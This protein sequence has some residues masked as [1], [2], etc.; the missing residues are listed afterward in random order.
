MVVTVHNR[1]VIP[2]AV[3]PMLF[4][5]FRSNEPGRRGGLGLGLFITREIV[6]AHGG[7]IEVDSRE[8]AGTTFTFSLPRRVARAMLN[9]ERGAGP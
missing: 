9:R 4:E 7:S 2:S 3:L 1:G 6:E 5:P 8:G